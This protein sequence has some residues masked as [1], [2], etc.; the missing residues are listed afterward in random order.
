MYEVID[1][2]LGLNLRN[3]L[4]GLLFQYMKHMDD[5]WPHNVSESG[6]VGEQNID[7]LVI[8]LP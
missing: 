6:T 8:R 4:E 2:K 5:S 7:V 3:Q 1:W